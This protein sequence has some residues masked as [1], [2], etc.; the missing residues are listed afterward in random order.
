MLSIN[1]QLDKVTEGRLKNGKQTQRQSGC[2]KF[3]SFAQ[4]ARTQ[5]HLRK[6]TLHCFHVADISLLVIFIH[7][8]YFCCYTELC[9]HAS[10]LFSSLD[11]RLLCFCEAL[12]RVRGRPKIAFVISKCITHTFFFFLN[13]GN[14]FN[15][16]WLFL[17]FV[18]FFFSYLYALDH[19]TTSC[20]LPL[21][22]LSSL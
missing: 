9:K 20:C 18:F 11:P 19:I 15:L 12:L 1:N 13:N 2:S 4:L 21:Y 22:S 17:T 3:R 8:T 5:A 7:A 14:L 6:P 16:I 10:F